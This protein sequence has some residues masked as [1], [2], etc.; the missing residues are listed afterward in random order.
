MGKS[1]YLGTYAGI[2]IYLH[3]TFGFIVLIVVYFAYANAMSGESI[4]WLSAYILSIFICVIFHEYGHAIAAKKFGVKTR[5]IIIAPIGGVARMESMPKQPWKELVIAIA[6]PLVNVVLAI[7]FS[8]LF[9]LIFKNSFITQ[10]FDLE[11][12]DFESY[13]RLLIVLNIALFGFNLIPAFPMDGGRI[14]RALLAMRFGKLKAT[15][16]ASWVGKIL[17]A[18]FV[19]CG[20]WLGMPIWA[21]IGMFVFYMANSENKQVKIQHSLT[22][23]VV[24]D[25]SEKNYP[26]LYADDE[27]SKLLQSYE[28]KVASNFLIF[29]REEKVV[30]AVPEIFIRNFKKE[31]MLGSQKLENIMSQTFGFFQDTD[32]LDLV[33]NQMNESGWSIAGVKKGEQ[34][35]GIVDRHLINSFLKRNT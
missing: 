26:M 24:G 12:K 32:K 29:S 13:L 19:V 35:I 14:L 30:G 20:I 6:G 5:D 2:P 1:L 34:L 31:G 7:A 28:S 18:V 22:N 15:H 27:L 16:I 3:W 17:A 21:F 25:I 4:F 33:F 23:S 8:L 9:F 10:D 11:S